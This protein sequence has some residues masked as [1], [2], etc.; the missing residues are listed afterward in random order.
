MTGRTREETELHTEA[1]VGFGNTK[2]MMDL[3]LR[4]SDFLKHR[5]RQE[6][7]ANDYEVENNK[8]SSHNKS[9]SQRVSFTRYPF[10]FWHQKKSGHHITKTRRLFHNVTS[11]TT[12]FV[13][14]NKS[15]AVIIRVVV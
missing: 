6:R 13:L 7:S 12:V 1:D 8:H 9:K 15:L 11:I 4:C 5:K 10:L 2:S 14:K 3:N